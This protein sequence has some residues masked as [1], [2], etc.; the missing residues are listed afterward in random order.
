[1]KKAILFLQISDS[2][3]EEILLIERLVQQWE[4]GRNATVYALVN[5]LSSSFVGSLAERVVGVFT[6]D[7]A[8]NKEYFDEIIN[9][10]KL[11]AIVLLDL[12][13]Y[14]IVPELLNFLPVWLQA[15]EIPI[16][17]LD[18]YNLLMYQDEQLILN[19]AIQ[20]NRFEAGEGPLPLDLQ[21]K[22]LKPVPPVIPDSE[23]DTRSQVCFW[24]AHEPAFK[25]SAPQ[26]REQLLDSL[27]AKPNSKI[28]FMLF[29]I[30]MFAKALEQNILGYYFVVVEV[31]IY[32]LQQFAGQHFQLLIVGLSPPTSD[33]NVIPDLNIDLHY[34]T[35]LTEDNYQ[36]FMAAS[37]LII[38]NNT[39]SVAL[40]DAMGLETPVCVLGNSIIQD[41]KDEKE[42]EK[43]LTSFFQPCQPLYDLCQLMVNLNQWSYSLPIF[44]FLSYPM[45]FYE[46]DFPEPGLQKHA[47][48]YYLLDMFDDQ[49]SFPILQNLLFSASAQEAHQELCRELL[50][51]GEKAHSFQRILESQ[52]D[53]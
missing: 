52:T 36:A 4:E 18:Y 25:A 38:A 7:Q 40:M 19:P 13:N 26:Y 27:E 31:I 37:D 8:K 35:H 22:L 50:K 41:W 48:P 39:W 20:L 5:G 34:F 21:L 49:T 14:F 42:E 45:P 9:R 6:E 24:N 43:H 30:S 11:E 23:Q 29:D 44:Q 16:F 17:A 47:F 46:P 3:F 51:V 1:M 2:A 10:E 12:Y 32:Y 28:I 33:I 15:L 53:E